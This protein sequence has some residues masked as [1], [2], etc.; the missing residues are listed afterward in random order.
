MHGYYRF[1]TINKDTIVFVCEDDLWTVPVQG[2]I[3]RR[4]TSNLGEVSRPLLSPDGRLVAFTGRE[5]GN[6]E[7]YVMPAIGGVARRITFLGADSLVVGW[8][9]SGARVLFSSNAGSPFFRFLHIYSVAVTKDEPRLVPVGPAS[10]ISYGPGKGVVIGRNVSDPARWK[11]Y[12]GGRV[13]DIW[14]D[15][16]GDR[17]FRRLLQLKSNL[18]NAMWIGGRIY[19]VSDHEG[20]GNIYSC[21]PAGKDIKRHTDHADYYVR[22]ATTDGNRIVYHAGADIYCLDPHKGR[23]R[24]IRIRHESPRVQ[25]HRKFVDA[26]TYLE[27]YAVHP[28]GKAVALSA[29]GKTFS[30]DNWIG[31]VHQHGNKAGV[32]YR[33][34]RWLHDRRI[35]LVADENGTD[36]LQVHAGDNS[37]PPRVLR[38]LD[39]GRVA[40]LEP[41]PKKDMVALTNHRFEIM[42]VNLKSGSCRIVDKSKYARIADIAWSADG[43]WFAYSCWTSERTSGIK[44]ASIEDRTVRSVTVPVRQD[45]SPSFDPDGR[46]LFF[47]SNREF[48][49]VYDTIQFDLGFPNNIKAY[50]VTLR[51][52]VC[53]PLR[54][55]QIMPPALEMPRRDAETAKPARRIDID[56]A[57]IETRVVALPLPAAR[58]D[59]LRAIKDK[60]L[61]S[62]CPVEGS[63]DSWD[64]DSAT[65]DRNTLA[66]Y[67]FKDQKCVPITSGITNFAVSQDGE[68]VV[69][70][71]RNRLRVVKPVE[72]VEEKLDREGVG[73]K[74]GWIDLGRV[75]VMVVPHDEWH[76]MYQD[77]WRLQRDHFWT[78]NM[79]G[80]DWVGVYKKYYPLLERVGSRSEF[81]DLIWE[82]QG[83]LG[84]SHAYEWG[85]DYRPE[86]HYRMGFL[87]AEL[88]YSKRRDAYRIKRI[89]KGDPWNERATSP[90]LHPGLMLREGDLITAVEGVKVGRNQ[91]PQELLVNRAGAEIALT[92]TSPARSRSRIVTVKT[93]RDE[94]ALRYREWV[95]QNRAIVHEK[96]GGTMGYVHIP[97]MGPWGYAEFHRYFLAEIEFSGLIVDVRYNRGGHVSQLLLGKL[98]RKR[99][100]YTIQRWGQPEPYPRE[101]VMGPIVCVTNEHAGSD[102]DI[103]SHCFKLYKLGPL[104]G[105]R[106]WGGVIGIRPRYGLADGGLTTQPEYS[107]WFMDVGWGVENY[108]T[109]P[110]IDV[111]YRPQDYLRGFDPQLNRALEECRRLMRKLK[112]RL[113]VFGG[114]PTLK[115]PRRLPK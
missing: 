93:L 91:S 73:P 39:I 36:T 34:G 87:G 98:A 75:R 22:N 47:L 35:V 44:I 48:N 9:K 59:R 13:G 113:P 84:T 67:D 62:A 72:R 80:I 33:L 23:S 43:Q 11:R 82:M 24:M 108:G 99:V 21:T 79:S 31:P 16:K 105:K 42:L 107:F 101:S 106:T 38:G 61:Y 19:F 2:G 86:P 32:R 1:P 85:G 41:N 56:F 4:L 69:Y 29:R 3:A 100:A 103:F 10:E 50:L 95:E 6:A 8:D 58:Y 78:R 64:D 94:S 51:K 68:A 74:S 83:E 7:V 96:S 54:Y 26:S 104:V 112:P 63:I 52:D 53:P 57:G 18:A 46:F 12:R 45:F 71:S 77:A 65:R 15:V 66:Y 40:E 17:Q 89:L 49:P 28:E 20:I 70:R 88:E 111:D 60:V 30:L 27:D 110:D 97:D 114:K 55:S 37:R 25:L 14:I 90:L 115:A 76:Q 109:D 102:G 92:V 5:E 81:S